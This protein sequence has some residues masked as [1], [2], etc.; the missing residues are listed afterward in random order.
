MSLA[1]SNA[2]VATV[3]VN[4]LVPAG[5]TTGRFIITNYMVSAQTIVT[6]TATYGASS[7]TI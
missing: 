1:S 5:Q 3:P 2:T 4:A 7:Q 6:I